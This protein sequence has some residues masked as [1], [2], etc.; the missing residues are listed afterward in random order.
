MTEG[1]RSPKSDREKHEG[2]E[3]E[4]PGG[5]ARHTLVSAHPRERPSVLARRGAGRAAKTA[6]SVP[7]QKASV[8]TMT[9]CGQD[10]RTEGCRLKPSKEEICLKLKGGGLK[11]K[12]QKSNKV[13]KL[14]P[15]PRVEANTVRRQDEGLFTLQVL[16]SFTGTYIC[17]S[18]SS[19]PSALFFTLLSQLNSFTC[20]QAHFFFQ[21]VGQLTPP[22]LCSSVSFS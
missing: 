5:P 14:G 10:W 3:E 7:G 18:S 13:G 1:S 16:L 9:Y 15:Y 21:W 17:P 22:M 4:E 11:R 12:K 19:F 6:V 20:L 8:G 2:V